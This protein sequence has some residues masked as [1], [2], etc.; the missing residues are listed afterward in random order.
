MID[1]R[2]ASW[3][4]WLLIAAIATS[5]SIGLFPVSAQANPQWWSR[6]FRSRPPDPPFE[7]GGRPT[8]SVFCAIA[9]AR[10]LPNSERPL[11][12]ID[13]PT[14][15][16]QGN[17]QAVEL[18]QAEQPE[19][20]WKWDEAEATGDRPQAVQFT[21][22]TAYRL[23]A[24][25]VLE[26]NQ[27]YEWRVYRPLFRHAIVIRFNAISADQQTAI[28]QNL[29]SSSD[30]ASVIRRADYLASQQLWD[31]FWQEMLSIDQP[32]DPL[33]QALSETISRL[34]P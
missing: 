6:I 1:T 9:P 16:W 3:H 23:T 5:F 27:S 4:R 18:W 14:L 30:E 25:I 2:A 19:P 29:P 21:T 15:V 10:T 34:C 17:L 26:P 8:G 20:L 33:N 24:D 32:S 7:G 12:S 22:E 13:R 28:E 31:D 11:A